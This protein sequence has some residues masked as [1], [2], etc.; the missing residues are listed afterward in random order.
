MLALCGCGSNLLSGSSDYALTMT[1][2]DCASQG[3]SLSSDGVGCLSLQGSGYVGGGGRVQ[4]TLTSGRTPNPASI[5][6]DAT[7]ADYETPLVVPGAACKDGTYN[8][9]L[10]GVLW[11]AN[12]PRDTTTLRV[13][14]Q[15]ASRS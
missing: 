4:L 11:V 10:K 2:V 3:Q 7:Y 1:W 14:C 9:V 13:A 12:Q 15:K 5:A 8:D 6:L